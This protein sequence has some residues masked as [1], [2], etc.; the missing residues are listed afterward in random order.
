MALHGLRGGDVLKVEAGEGEAG[1]LEALIHEGAGEADDPLRIAEQIDEALAGAQ[2]PPEGLTE[3]AGDDAPEPSFEDVSGQGAL[4]AKA[5]PGR[6]GIDDLEAEPAKRPEGQLPELGILHHDGIGR[7]PAL[8]RGADAGDEDEAG[9]DG[10]LTPLGGGGE[11]RQIS[12]GDGVIA[13]AEGVGDGAPVG[14][15]GV[16][17]SG[18]LQPAAV[19]GGVIGVG[20]LPEVAGLGLVIPAHVID[21]LG[22]DPPGE[23]SGP[24]LTLDGGQALSGDDLLAEAEGGGHGPHTV[25]LLLAHLAVGEHHG[26]AGGDQQ[27]PEPHGVQG[28]SGLSVVKGGGAEGG[29]IIRQAHV[30]EEAADEGLLLR[31]DAVAGGDVVEPPGEGEGPGGG[32]GLLV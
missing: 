23:I 31:G 7:A 16:L 11:A 9:P 8:E 26:A 2:R 14:D 6:S 5:G 3:A 21:G 1:V 25:A 22:G 13:G 29:E 28:L 30:P 32:P 24:A 15:E 10:P 12:R 4:A 20:E 19:G 18:D 17:A 27:P